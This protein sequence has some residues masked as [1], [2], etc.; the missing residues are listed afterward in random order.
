MKKTII[1][2]KSIPPKAVNLWNGLNRGWVIPWHINSRALLLVGATQLPI[3]EMN[4]EY[5]SIRD[6]VRR[7]LRQAQV[8]DSIESVDKDWLST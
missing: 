6:I 5:L 1:G 4:K 3:I 2:E 8:I 7:T